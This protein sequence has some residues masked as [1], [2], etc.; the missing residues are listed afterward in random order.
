MAT[1]GGKM[2]ENSIKQSL[3]KGQNLIDVGKIYPKKVHRTKPIFL[4]RY[5]TFR[6]SA[7]LHTVLQCH[8]IEHI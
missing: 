4:H 3:F 5:V 2:T 8:T 6:N 1:S 7:E